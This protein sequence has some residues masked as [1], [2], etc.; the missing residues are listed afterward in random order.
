MAV[1]KFLLKRKRN[2]GNKPFIVPVI[3]IIEICDTEEDCL[4]MFY[5]Y[6]WEDGD[7]FWIEEVMK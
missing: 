6:L 7:E 2:L 5:E 3:N 1:S 4:E